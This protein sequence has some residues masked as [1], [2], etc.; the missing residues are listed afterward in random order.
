V[1]FTASPT[2]SLV[3]VKVFGGGPGSNVDFAK[4]NFHIPSRRASTWA[5]AACGRAVAKKDTAKQETM[6]STM[7]DERLVNFI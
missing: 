7:G 2:C 4:F 5:K 6:P 3:I 1:Y